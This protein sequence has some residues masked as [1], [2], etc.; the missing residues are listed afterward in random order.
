MFI[1]GTFFAK[2][3]LLSTAMLCKDGLWDYGLSLETK[4]FM[5]PP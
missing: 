1:L 4:V 2:G 5:L 3:F